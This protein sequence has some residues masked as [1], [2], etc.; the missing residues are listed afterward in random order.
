M[1]ID[2]QLLA[3]IRTYMEELQ[4]NGAVAYVDLDGNFAGFGNPIYS[5]EGRYDED[6]SEFSGMYS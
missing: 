2:A 3:Q 6:R 4:S 5:P 1:A